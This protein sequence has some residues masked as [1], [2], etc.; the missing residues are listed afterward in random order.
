M[1]VGQGVTMGNGSRCVA[2]AVFVKD[3]SSGATVFWGGPA[4]LLKT[5]E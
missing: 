1:F 2:G 3:V 4:K 5:K